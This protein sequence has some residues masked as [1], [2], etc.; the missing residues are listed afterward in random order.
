M[1]DLRV[2]WKAD[3]GWIID[4]PILYPEFVTNRVAEK[5]LKIQLDRWRTLIPGEVKD[6]CLRTIEDLNPIA[7]DQLRKDNGILILRPNIPKRRI[8]QRIVG[9]RGDCK[10]D[11]VAFQA[12][13][14]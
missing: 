5:M 2:H 1:K 8:Q 14:Y 6:E 11:M 3:I 12:G 9:Q 13:R 10:G 7:A 4:V